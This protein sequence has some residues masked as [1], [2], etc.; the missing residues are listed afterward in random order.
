MTKLVRNNDSADKINKTAIKV[1]IW[2]I[3]TSVVLG[4]IY[5]SSIWVGVF[6]LLSD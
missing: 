2:L 1:L 3:V 4:V 6:L 5:V